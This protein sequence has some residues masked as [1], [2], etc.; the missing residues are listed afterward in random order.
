MLLDQF[1]GA[2]RDQ[3]AHDDDRHLANELAPAVHRLG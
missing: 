1:L 2:E 3:H